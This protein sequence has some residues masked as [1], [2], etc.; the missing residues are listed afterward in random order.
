MEVFRQI[1]PEAPLIVAEAVWQY[2][3]HVL[4]GLL[5]HDGPIL[6]VANWSGTWPGLVGMLN[7]NGSLTKAGR[8]YSTLWSEDF[9]DKFVRPQ[10]RAAGSTRARSSTRP[11]TSR[12]WQ[13][14]KV[15]GE[16]RRLGAA[17]AEQL[18]REKAIMG[19]FDEGC[20]G[21]FNAIIPDHLLHPTGVFKERL[22]QSALYYETTQ[23]AD[24]E[25]RAVRALDGSA[26]HEV[27]HRHRTTPRI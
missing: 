4:R 21:M 8:K 16:E 15:P 3:H 13:N 2:S 27:R 1:D 12:R 23:V 24:D 9:T 14:V 26:R 7:L 6:T 20:M 25:A 10:P 22:S 17:L 19:V 18:R 11:T 5:S